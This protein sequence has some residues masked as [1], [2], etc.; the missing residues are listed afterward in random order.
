MSKT[1]VSIPA[2]ISGVGR[3]FRAVKAPDAQPGGRIGGV[4]NTG[5]VFNACEAVLGRK[6][7]DDLDSG[8]HHQV[9]IASA[10]SID[11]G[12]IGNQAD[13]FSAQFA[14][15]IGGQNVEPGSRVAVADRCG[16]DGGDRAPQRCNGRAYV[17]MNRIR[18]Q[19]DVGFDAGSIQ[20]DVPVKP[21][22]PKDDPAGK[23]LP[24]LPEYRES[25]SQPRPRTSFCPAGDAAE[26]NRRMVEGLK[27]PSPPSRIAWQIF[28]QIVGGGEDTGVTGHA[29][30]EARGRIVNH[31]AQDLAV[32][33]LFGGRDTRAQ[34]RIGQIAGFGHPERR[35]NIFPRR[36]RFPAFRSADGRFRRAESK[37]ISL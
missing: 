4:G 17:R 6:E 33:L 19:N 37:L 24:R 23:R 1:S 10:F 20:I 16:D 3:S 34:L 25:I 2:S 13:S 22:C 18:Q 14:E 26:A 31:A 15:I 35:E 32:L 8:L 12:L 36:T 11:T 9:D 27:R 7:R 29:S 21:V 30:H 28:R 5:T